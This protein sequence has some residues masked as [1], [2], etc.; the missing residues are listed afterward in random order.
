MSLPDTPVATK[1]DPS[2]GPLLPPT[3]TTGPPFT[4]GQ[5]VLDDEDPHP[6]PAIVIDITGKSI[7]E[8]R[9][10]GTSQK[11]IADVNPTY[12]VDEP[13]VTVAFLDDFRERVPNSIVY[14]K[15]LDEPFKRDHP[16]SIPHPIHSDAVSHGVSCYTYP[17]CRLNAL[18]TAALTVTIDSTDGYTATV[19][20]VRCLPSGDEE[21]TTI[22]P[23]IRMAASPT[24]AGYRAILAGLDAVTDSENPITRLAINIDNM[25]LINELCTATEPDSGA[26]HQ[27]TYDK[28]RARLKSLI[29]VRC[30][31]P[32]LREPF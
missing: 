22:T 21:T 9:L 12:P 15:Q 2:R 7:S 26:F 5:A 23:D 24:D 29:S 18:P 14:Y 13:A 27:Q 31:R 10:P 17:A 20:I 1:A 11:T 16:D 19:K 30:A 32:T 4:I 25:D 3:P 28:V 6:S 8:T